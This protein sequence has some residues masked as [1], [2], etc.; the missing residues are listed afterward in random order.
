MNP[1]ED[2]IVAIRPILPVLPFKLGDSIRRL[3]TTLAPG[4][5]SPWN[6]TNIDP[7]TN[8]PVT[9]VNNVTNFGW[10]YV[11][12]CHILGHEENDMMRAMSL[13][14]SPAKPL[15]LAAANSA[16]GP[17]LPFVNL[18][19]TLP[20]SNPVATNVLLQRATN[21]AFTA[22]LVSTSLPGAPV[23]YTDNTVATFTQY[24]YRVR[25][26]TAAGFSDW[27]NVASITTVGQ[28]PNA[29]RNLIVTGF[30]AASISVRWTAPLPGG[31]PVQ[32]FLVQTALASGGPWTT[33]VTTNNVATTAVIPGL[34]RG[35]TY[36]I[37]VLSSNPAGTVPSNTVQQRL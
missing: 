13:I 18:T 29:P 25:A 33:R 4:A 24:F 31:G 21:A 27:S 12:H 7:F 26:E 17:G 3:D 19:W 10:E 11:W 16:P 28:L 37:R 32:N 20:A 8:T 35:R 2:I 15:S 5:T 23:A 1:L 36:F 30:T 22:G 34:A 14:V 9:T 6:F